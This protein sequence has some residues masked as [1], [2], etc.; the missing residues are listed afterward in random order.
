MGASC[1][2]EFENTKQRKKKARTRMLASHNFEFENTTRE[3][4]SSERSYAWKV[5][6]KLSVREHHAARE[7]ARTRMGKLQL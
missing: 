6:K 1:N 3:H 4:H 5:C 2:F 7:E